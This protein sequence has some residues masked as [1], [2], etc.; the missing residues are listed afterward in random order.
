MWLSDEEAQSYALMIPDLSFPPLPNSPRP[1]ST[2]SL[3][4]VEIRD[5][6]IE[7]YLL[8]L[9]SSACFWYLNKSLEGL[10]PSP[11]LEESYQWLSQT[12]D[13]FPDNEIDGTRLSIT[14]R[15]HISAILQEGVV[16]L[17][18]SFPS[19]WTGIFFPTTNPWMYSFPPWERPTLYFWALLAA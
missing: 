4:T 13:P 15:F 11:K 12:Q 17:Q 10:F 9:P 18:R 3:N 7:Y 6:N 14:K 2:V 16:P 19:W 5:S 8:F 1:D